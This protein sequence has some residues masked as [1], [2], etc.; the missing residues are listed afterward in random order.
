MVIDVLSV[1]LAG[2]WDLVHAVA[3]LPMAKRQREKKT[4]FK[5][6]PYA[7]ANDARRGATRAADRGSDARART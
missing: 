6:R 1:A 3:R 7:N 4:G 5:Q 2:A